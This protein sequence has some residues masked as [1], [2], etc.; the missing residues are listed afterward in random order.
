M[1]QNQ[2]VVLRRRG[3]HL[4]RAAGG[5]WCLASE[6]RRE[7]HSETVNASVSCYVVRERWARGACRDGAVC[8]GQQPP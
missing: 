2:M 3:Y 1:R 6:A 7:D 5:G 4:R 8:A